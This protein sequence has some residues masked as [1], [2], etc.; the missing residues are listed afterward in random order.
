MSDYYRE[1]SPNTVRIGRKYSRLASDLVI[2]GAGWM[3]I[4]TDKS[5]RR[6]FFQM[7]QEE[8]SG[9]VDLKFYNDRKSPH[10]YSRPRLAQ[11][12]IVQHEVVGVYAAMATSSTDD[13]V[14]VDLTEPLSEGGGQL[15]PSNTRPRKN[16]YQP[17]SAAFE[18][19][20]LGV[21]PIGVA[22]AEIREIAQRYGVNQQRL[23]A[24]VLGAAKY[25]YTVIRGR[26][27]SIR[28]TSPR[29]SDRS[30]NRVSQK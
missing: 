29:R 7:V 21:R 23:M 9:A 16:P 12:G 26:K 2:D 3:R 24:T 18:A 1:V 14:A 10:F 20:R 22:S 27:G 15:K 19:F 28:I 4:A 6:L 17:R 5:Q 11:I 13:R 8:M 30:R 25:G